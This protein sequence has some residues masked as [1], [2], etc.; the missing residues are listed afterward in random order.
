MGIDLKYDVEAIETTKK[1]IKKKKNDIETLS[2][3]LATNFKSLEGQW[4]TDAAKKF[5]EIVDGDW[6]DG[7]K[8]VSNVLLD[9]ENALDAAAKEYQKIEDEAKATFKE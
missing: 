9:L 8:A 7:V 6:A 4:N 1:S 2:K 3:A 5:F